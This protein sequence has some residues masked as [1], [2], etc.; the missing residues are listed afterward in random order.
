MLKKIIYGGVV[1]GWCYVELCC[2]WD[3]VVVFGIWMR[4]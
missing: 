1:F 4:R 2:G 3:R